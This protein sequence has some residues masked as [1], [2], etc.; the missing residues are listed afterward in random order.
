MAVAATRADFFAALCASCEGRLEQRRL[1][2]H[3]LDFYQD[4]DYI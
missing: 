2:G 4:P 3:D 1:N